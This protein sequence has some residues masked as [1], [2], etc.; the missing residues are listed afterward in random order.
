MINNIIVIVV[1]IANIFYCCLFDRIT[2]FLY[3][4]LK[5][6]IRNYRLN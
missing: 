4:F 2:S 5:K 3:F 1:L 6:I